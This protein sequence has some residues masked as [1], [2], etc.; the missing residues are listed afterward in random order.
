LFVPDW[1]QGHDLGRK[2]KAFVCHDGTFS[3]LNQWATEELFFTEH[4][5]GGTLWENRKAYEKWDPAYHTGKWQTPTLII[6]S[7]LDYRLPIS[8][9]LAM[10]N[11]LQARGVPSKL[12]MFPD[13]NHV[14]SPRVLSSTVLTMD[15]QWVLKPEN[16]LV[17]HREVLNW[18][19]HF[20][21]IAVDTKL[22]A[23]I[24]KMRV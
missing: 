17:W 4:D 15:S 20:S 2:F 1:I 19:N 9:G 14:G 5:F 7:E 16:S 3:T 10:F 6:H 23:E 24:E 18:I 22:E 11:V 13:E 8:E 21:G 12:V